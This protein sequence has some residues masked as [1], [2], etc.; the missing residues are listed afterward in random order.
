MPGKRCHH[1]DDA[2]RY[3]GGRCKL[4]AREKAARRRVPVIP[5]RVQ[6]SGIC[7]PCGKNLRLLAPIVRPYNSRAAQPSLYC[8]PECR[9]HYTYQTCVSLIREGWRIDG[10]GN[11]F[12]EIRDGRMEAR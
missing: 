9:A 8:S 6:A 7:C 10:E 4:C 12:A 1:G 3:A 5:C 2:P 11:G